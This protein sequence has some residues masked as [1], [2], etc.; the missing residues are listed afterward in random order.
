[1]NENYAEPIINVIVFAQEDI[2][3]TS[4]SDGDNVLDDSFFD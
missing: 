3:T 1:M 4:P 2:I